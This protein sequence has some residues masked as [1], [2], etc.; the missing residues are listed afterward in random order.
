VDAG[1]LA[2]LKGEALELGNEALGLGAGNF[3]QRVEGAGG[4]LGGVG[5]VGL[6]GVDSLRGYALVGGGRG[7]AWG[8][9]YVGRDFG[10]CIAGFADFGEEALAHHF[11]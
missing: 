8:A 10:N 3:G 4:G 6:Q 11:G 2:L 5:G 1:L 9:A 7:G